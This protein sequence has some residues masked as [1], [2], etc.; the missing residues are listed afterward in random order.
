MRARQSNEI[1]LDSDLWFDQ[2]DAIATARRA[3]I[4][5]PAPPDSLDH[6]VNEGYMIFTPELDPALINAVNHDVDRIWSRGDDIAYAC[7]SVPLSLRGADANRQRRPGCRLHDL[8]GVSEAARR[9][10]LD[11]GLHGLVERLF[12]EPVVA[13]QSLYFEFGS[14]QALHR[15][16]QVVPV[17]PPAHLLAIWIALEDI[18]SDSG[19]LVVAP[20]SHRLPYFRF[21]TG[22]HRLPAN[23]SE[24]EICRGLA[25]QER[26]LRTNQITPKDFLPRVGQALCWHHSLLHGGRSVVDPRRTRRSLVI[27]YSTR[28][29]Y[30]QR[31]ITV[32]Q[33]DPHG[34]PTAGHIF[35]TSELIAEDAAVGFAAPYPP[36]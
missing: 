25:W 18:H 17:T 6:F 31:G 32:Y 13:I 3:A 11:P 35:R 29:H 15:D 1:E 5:G 14:G 19:P 34:Q 36:S 23:A 7:D 2:P 12:G 27:H 9:L 21:A 20:R 28:R 24:D 30:D 8:H 33:T 10:Y 22:D 16:P 4:H 26:Q